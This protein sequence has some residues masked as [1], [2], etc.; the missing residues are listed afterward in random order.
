MAKRILDIRKSDLIS[1][2]KKNKIQSLLMGEGRGLF[3]EIFS[4]SPALLGNVSNVELAAGFGADVLLL[5]DYYAFEPM[6]QG[7]PHQ[8]EGNTIS[9]IK[10][11]TGRMVGVDL[12]VK[13]RSKKEGFWPPEGILLSEA[14]LSKLVDDGV[15]LINVVG[16]PE[17]GVT[18]EEIAEAINQIPEGLKQQVVIVSGRMNKAGIPSMRVHEMLPKTFV[19]DLVDAGVDIVMLPAPGSV[20]GFSVDIV[21]ELVDY[22]H[23]LG[24]M[25][26]TAVGTSQEGA[27]TD[28]IKTIALNAKMCG[29]NLHHLGDSGMVTGVAS[30][31]NILSYSI[32]I[33]GKKHTYRRMTASLKR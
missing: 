29:T 14:N 31:E 23:S 24:V 28:T 15:D 27:D 10:E 2:T 9:Q 12:Y 17:Q 3:C 22:C 25:T 26:L 19:K 8:N 11:L 20:P 32:A 13:D 6:V 7:M 5:N 33:K 21:S 30:P 18:N 16:D 1:M 4:T